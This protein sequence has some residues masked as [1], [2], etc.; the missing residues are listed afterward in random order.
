VPSGW[1]YRPS[2]SVSSAGG[3]VRHAKS[4]AHPIE[5]FTDR[6][7]CSAALPGRDGEQGGRG[8]GTRARAEAPMGRASRREALTASIAHEVNQTLAGWH[9]P[10]TIRQTHRLRLLDADRPSPRRQGRRRSTI[11]GTAIDATRSL[12]S[13]GECSRANDRAKETST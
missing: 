9:F 3:Q 2:C 1:R 4:V 13:F 10:I 12:K 5:H 11:R 7:R 6:A 8:A